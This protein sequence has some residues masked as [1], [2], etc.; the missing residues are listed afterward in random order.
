MRR[1]LWPAPTSQWSS[2]K[3]PRRARAGRSELRPAKEDRVQQKPFSQVGRR[4][5]SPFLLTRQPHRFRRQPHSDWS[6][7]HTVTRSPRRRSQRPR[8]IRSA[9][10]S[11]QG[12]WFSASA[13]ASPPM[14][15]LPGAVV[16]GTCSGMC[17]GAAT[18]PSACCWGMGEEQH[19]AQTVC[20]AFPACSIG[21]RAPGR[22]G[23]L[24]GRRR[25]GGRRDAALLPMVV[26]LLWPPEV[27]RGASSGTPG[28]RAPRPGPGP[29]AAGGHPRR[30]AELS[31]EMQ[32]THPL[33]TSAGGTH[34]LPPLRT[35][36]KAASDRHRIRPR[37]RWQSLRASTTPTTCGN[38]MDP[39][40]GLHPPGTRT[41]RSMSGRPRHEVA[42]KPQLLL[43][44]LVL[45]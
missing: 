6:I 10:D 19:P 42:S 2:S 34:L 29:R 25:R 38:Q 45:S 27:L 31:R 9:L 36:P 16:R 41:P 30:G 39:T 32:L 4:R 12:A 13:M 33:S 20:R 43:R 23:R 28:P 37:A 40:S 44:S 1:A 17:R 35:C 15:H 22:G 18:N 8:T 7:D 24:Y 14:S 26:M 21:C 3:E 5:P 11:A